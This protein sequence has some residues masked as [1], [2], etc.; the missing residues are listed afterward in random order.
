MAKSKRQCKREGN[1]WV[2]GYEKAD[3]TE[4]DGYCRDD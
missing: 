4:V 2:R 3:G 1:T